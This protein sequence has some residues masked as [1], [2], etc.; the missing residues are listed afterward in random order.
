MNTF[1]PFEITDT[2]EVIRRDI[3]DAQIAGDEDEI[4]AL[5]EKLD[6]LY[7]ERSEKHEDY[8]HV[9]RN[10]EMEAKAL[11][12]LAKLLRGT[13]LDDMIQHGEKQNNVGKFRL[14]RRNGAR[15]VLHID[16]GDLPNFR[17]SDT[18]YKSSLGWHCYETGTPYCSLP[19]SHCSKWIK[20]WRL[21]NP[22]LQIENIKV[23]F[24]FAPY[25]SNPRRS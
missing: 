14:S 12:T 24:R 5:M 7:S 20:D 15:V 1:T 4:Q 22:R 17:L 6:A 3:I 25:V 10:A 21:V 11:N 9:I 18:L 23:D 19:P 8:I 2:L 16:A 13:L